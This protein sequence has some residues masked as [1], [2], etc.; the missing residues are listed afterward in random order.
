MKPVI[1]D[2]A[3]ADCAAII[4]RVGAGKSYTAR[5]LVERVLDRGERLCVIDPTGV[6][7]GLRLG[8]DGKKAGYP[9][10]VFG[11]DYA[12]VKIGE[13]SGPALAELI[14]GRNLP[15]VLD[16]SEFTIGARTRFLTQF[17]ETLYIKNP[18]TPLTLV[19]DEADMVAP[20]RIQPDQT[21]MF[22]RLEQ[23]VRR[24]RVRG[25][26]PWLITQR[27]AE[28]HK[29]VL[30]QAATLIALKLTSPQDRKAA[31]E[32]VM[33][34]GDKEQGK[35][36]LA[37]LAGLNRGEGWAWCPGSDILERVQFPK[38]KTYDSM[39]TPQVGSSHPSPTKLSDVDLS[40]IQDGLKAV[41]AEVAAN[42]P[43]KLKARIAELEKKIAA[44]VFAATDP[45]AIQADVDR[46]YAAGWA[47]G[48]K[49]VSDKI[50]PFIGAVRAGG[51]QATF[52]LQALAAPQGKSSPPVVRV[53]PARTVPPRAPQLN[54][55]VHHAPT[56]GALKPSLQRVV[57]AIGWWFKV[58]R[59]PV[60]RDRAAVV[61]GYSPR[62]STFG[63]YIAEL[64]K[65]GLV[66]VG[67]GTVGLTPEG[68][69]LAEIPDAATREDLFS[70]AR[71]LLKPQ[72]AKVFEVVYNAYPGEIA[73]EKVAECVGLSPTAST[74]SVYIAGVAAYGIIE[75]A[76]RGHMKAAE[77]LFP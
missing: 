43:R 75:T 52:D 53:A 37:S 15:C 68:F 29:S 77:W 64:A 22:S 63:V 61:A 54:G 38:I 44:T 50:A 51:D 34:H 35:E 1:P 30:S 48:V 41:E 4:G 5:G 71:G 17:L 20:Q 46:G 19:V 73:R 18:K 56:D 26:R 62:A 45:A 70:V 3:L 6:W 13:H 36:V 21:V 57:N 24:G 67:N 2:S 32:W 25:F 8:A 76:S 59:Y 47:A 40:A 10:V 9:V 42:D 39:R 69:K 28:L 7:W 58:G 60:A 33:G 49:A 55:A 23:I 11:G 72:E 14:A 12:D 27:P 65:M 31:E 16:V 74:V 66:A